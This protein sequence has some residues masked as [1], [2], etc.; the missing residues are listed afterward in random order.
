MKNCAKR[1]WYF[2]SLL[3]T[4]IVGDGNIFPLMLDLLALGL[5]TEKRNDKNETFEKYLK[6]V[7]DSA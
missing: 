3:G 5:E 4:C 6:S 7:C 1:E 2:G